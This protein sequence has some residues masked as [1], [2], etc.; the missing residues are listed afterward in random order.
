M[1]RVYYHI[2]GL[3][4]EYHHLD[5]LNLS[6]ALSFYTILS[7]LPIL[8]IVI[9]V[10]GNFL[11][12][13]GELYA[14]LSE[15]IE[16]IIPN[17]KTSLLGNLKSI[18]DQKKTFGGGALI[19][20]FLVSHYLF[21]NLEKTVN[22]IFHAKIKRHFLIKRL[23]SL[24]WLSGLIILFFIPTLLKG[25]FLFVQHKGFLS[26]SD[27]HVP[28]MLW[29]FILSMLTFSMVILLV[30]TN[31]IKRSNV[32]L[33]SVLFAVLLKAAQIL[34]SIYTSYSLSRYNLV[35]GSLTALIMGVI[36]IFYFSNILLLC[37]LWVARRERV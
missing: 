11:G 12:E 9:S 16:S 6:A 36:W 33:G 18:V 26:V 24:V 34:F 22:K 15:L 1:K 4:A 35:Y 20:L 5:G 30:P 8:L 14:K 2:R 10:V 19:F 3:L 25:V 28:E 37:V 32:F 21:G 17:L 7:L 31:K 13:S 27:L 29:F 23:L